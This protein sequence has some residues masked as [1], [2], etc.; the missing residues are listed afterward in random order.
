[1]VTAIGADPV[2]TEVTDG[3]VVP[4]IFPPQGGRVIFA[5]ARVKN[6]DACGVT[7]TGA[8]RDL[9]TMQ[10]R[11]DARTVNL[12]ATADGYAESDPTDISSFSNIPVCPNQWATADI[13]EVEYELEIVV[14]DRG[15]RSVSKKLHVTPQCAEPER[16]AECRCICKGGYILGEVCMDA[17]DGGAG[18]SG[19]GG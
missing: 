10:V 9:S 12:V 3:S 14:V 8:L 4:L 16:E 6:I 2:A 18:G 7:L 15:G 17:M 19:G 11:V 13:F 1:M 5:G